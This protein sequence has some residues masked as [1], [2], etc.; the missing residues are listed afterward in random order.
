MDRKKNVLLINDNFAQPI[1]QKSCTNRKCYF[2]ADDIQVPDEHFWKI[3]NW[4]CS[5]ASYDFF[6]TI[7][8]KIVS[9]DTN[10]I[11]WGIRAKINY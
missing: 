8:F 9:Y 10:V 1:K 6:S 5:T 2:N 4:L 11:I 7:K 3:I